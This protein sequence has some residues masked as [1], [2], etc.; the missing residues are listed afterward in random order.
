MKLPLNQKVEMDNEINIDDECNEEKACEAYDTM[1]SLRAKEV[2]EFSL[3]VNLF[4][5]T[6][7]AI[8]AFAGSTLVERIPSK[9]WEEVITVSIFCSLGF[10]VSFICNRILQGSSFW[11]D[12]YQTRLGILE[13]AKFKKI[14]IFADHPSNKN[15]QIVE[16]VL[17]SKVALR[18]QRHFRYVSTRSAIMSISYAFSIMWAFILILSILT[19]LF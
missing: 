17:K 5:V 7:S 13:P 6:Q 12:Y 16:R 4:I 19:F 10:V 8:F 11:I 9:S 2:D 15:A 14:R 18:N 3:K 1:L